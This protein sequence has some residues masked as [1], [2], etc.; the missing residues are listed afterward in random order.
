MAGLVPAIVHDAGEIERGLAAFARAPSG[1]LIVV[2]G[3]VTVGYRDLIITLAAQHKLP[4]VY[5]SR[6][7][8]AAGGLISRTA[9]ALGFRIPAD[10][11]ALADELIEWWRR[12][13][14]HERWLECGT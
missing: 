11:L 13:P 4:A 10:V 1:G 9:K 6:Y 3:A 12:L 14:Q 7:L 2:G 8:V 5:Y